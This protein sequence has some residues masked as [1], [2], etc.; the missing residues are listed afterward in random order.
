M[1]YKSPIDI[2]YGNIQTKLEDDVVKAIQSYNI[3]VDKE[4]LIKALNYDREQYKAG[5]EDALKEISM[6]VNRYMG[7]L[8]P[9]AYNER[10]QLKELND[11]IAKLEGI[12]LD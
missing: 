1:S 2:I 4:E 11:Y 8:H 6:Y 10:A 3:S 12:N 7:E 5:Y 9:Q